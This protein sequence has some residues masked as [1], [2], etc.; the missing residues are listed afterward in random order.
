[1]ATVTNVATTPAKTADNITVEA[2]MPSQ[3]AGKTV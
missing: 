3:I 2:D 1:M